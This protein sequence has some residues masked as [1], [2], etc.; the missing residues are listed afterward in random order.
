MLPLITGLIKHYMDNLPKKS[1]L[2]TLCFLKMW[3][4]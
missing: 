4:T 1:P 3:K 2:Q